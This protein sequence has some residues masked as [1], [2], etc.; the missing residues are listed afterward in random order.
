MKLYIVCG[1]VNYEGYY[2]PRGVFSSIEEAKKF[3]APA[4]DNDDWVDIFE[5]ELDKLEKDPRISCRLGFSY[6]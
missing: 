6:D 2:K 1:A 4:D 3:S 5:Y